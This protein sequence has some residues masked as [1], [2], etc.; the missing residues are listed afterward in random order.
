LSSFIASS[1][2]KNHL[3]PSLFEIHPIAGTK[4]DP[5]FGDTLTNRLNIT[6][7]SCNKTLN[8]CLDA[9]PRLDIAKFIKP[10]CEERSVFRISIMK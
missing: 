10:M 9:C 1:Q 6:G 7:I 5:Q 3:R 8:P 2:E 4:V